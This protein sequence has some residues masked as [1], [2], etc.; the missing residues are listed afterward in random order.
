MV[1]RRSGIG[2][3]ALLAVSFAGPA[4]AGPIR[5]TTGDVEKDMP[6]DAPGV[7][8]IANHANDP[9]YYKQIQANWMNAAGR[10]NG[11]AIKDLRFQYD[12]ASDQLMVGVN[13]YGVGGDAYGDG[14]AGFHDSTRQAALANHLGLGSSEN[15]TIAVGVYLSDSKTPSFVAGIPSDHR[16]PALVGPGIDGFTVNAYKNSGAGLGA[17]FDPKGSLNAHNG[18]LAFEPSKDHPDFEFVIKDLS[19]MPGFDLKNGGIGF[20]AFAGSG[21]DVEVGE[22]SMTKTFFKFEPQ[23][24]TVPEP[25]SVLAWSALAVGAAWRGT[26]RRRKGEPVRS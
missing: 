8:T 24:V 23:E 9:A 16:D 10:I 17:S 6:S 2:A 4:M 26:A 7:T 15:Q 25:A 21:D 3:V 19:K 22:D 20:K 1:R 14:L 12:Q 13:F 18:G 11:W 5:F